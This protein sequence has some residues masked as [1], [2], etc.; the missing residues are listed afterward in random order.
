[1][2]QAQAHKWRPAEGDR[3]K[4]RMLI[5]TNPVQRHHAPVGRRTAEQLAVVD[6]LSFNADT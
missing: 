1:M 6:E 5:A 4:F 3:T 2:Q